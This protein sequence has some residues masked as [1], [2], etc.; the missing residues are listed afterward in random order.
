MKN[1]FMFVFCLI[2]CLCILN[3]NNKDATFDIEE[4]LNSVNENVRYMP[5]PPSL[6]DFYSI[7]EAR[8]EEKYLL[9]AIFLFISENVKILWS[10]IMFPFKVIWFFV[11][12]IDVLFSF[13]MLLNLNMISNIDFHQ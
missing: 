12:N 4:Y 8:E 6:S 9:K 1:V 7:E 5:L 13:R 3:Y 11:S 10:F 2:V